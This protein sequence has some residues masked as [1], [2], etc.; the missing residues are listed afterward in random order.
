[1]VSCDSKQ[2]YH[3]FKLLLNANNNALEIMGEIEKLLSQGRPFGM[4]SINA[5]C[6]AVLVNIYRMI[7]K[8]DRLAPGKY[9]ALFHRFDAIQSDINHILKEKPFVGDKRLVIFISDIDMTMTDLVGGKMANLGEVKNVLGVKVPDGFVLTAYACEYFFG[10]NNLQLEINRL[11]QAV[12]FDDINKPYKLSSQIQQLIINAKL[13]SDLKKAVEK[14]L[15][16]LKK[17]SGHSL[18][19]AL[20]SSARGEDGAGISFAGQYRTVLNVCVENI[21]QAYKEV[22]ASKYSVTAISYRMNRGFRDEDISMCV[23]CLAMVDPAAGGVV[24]SRNPFDINNDSIFIHSTWG[25]PK[26]VVDGSLNSDLFVVDRNPG[27]RLIQKNICEKD[28]KIVC[29]PEEGVCKIDIVKNFQ[30]LPSLNEKTIT[31]L[32]KL[33][34]KIESHYGA[35]QDIEWAVVGS[36]PPVIY[37]LQSRSFKQKHN[38][39]KKVPIVSKFDKEELIAGEG[40][41]A[42][43]GVAAGEAYIVDKRVDLLKFPEN[44]VLITRRALPDWAP[45]LNRACG[46]ITENGGFAGHL[47]SVAREFEVPALFCVPDICQK[48]KNGETITID[49]DGLCVYKGR[50]ESLLENKFKKKNLM[51][52]SPVYKTLKKVSRHISPLNLLDPDS[53]EFAISNCKTLH[54][55]TRF[56]HEKSVYEMFNFGK[57][58]DFEDNTSKQLYHHV[59]MQWWILNLEDGFKKEIAGKYVLLDD[60]S[61]VPMLALWEGIIAV[62]WEG[63]PP[64]NGKGLMSVMFQATANPALNLGMRSKY[65]KRNYFM[66]SRQYCSLSSRLGFHFSIL[67]TFVSERIRQNYISFRFQGGAADYERRLK[68]VRFVGNFLSDYGFKIEIKKDNMHAR[69]KGYEK[70]FMMDRLKIVGYLIT[71]TRQLDMITSSPGMIKRYHDKFKRDIESVLNSTF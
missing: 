48:I 22:V 56:I 14:A 24:Y 19:L 57:N 65:S 27:F 28:K 8:L 66:I 62:P 10:H 68:R 5:N 61:C 71:H 53:G 44:A 11:I 34:I 16:A 21:F 9:G 41:M 46:I 63:P 47:A 54:D 43:P 3:A 58:H 42:S 60:I 13:P 7:R 31:D 12:P 70:G 45:L 1:M 51:E 35:P 18:A 6:T 40:I 2:R 59:P 69:I 55:I 52:K 20:R 15:T 36:A 37:I 17:R 23:G 25:L 38:V 50:I 4:S 32:A 33:T 30:L 67:E 39:A 49:A 29:D 64:I 26:S